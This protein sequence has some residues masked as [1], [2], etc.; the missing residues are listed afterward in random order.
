MVMSQVPSGYARLEKS[1]RHAVKNAS[2][3]GPAEPSEIV[4]VSI[5]VRRRPGAPPLPGMDQWASTRFAERK[6]ISREE[7][8]DKYG[9]D[10][11]DLKQLEDVA[12]T[13]ELKVIESSVPRRTVRLSGTVAQMSA[14]FG[15]SLGRYKS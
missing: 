10:P 5:R 11:A 8:A 6:Y 7:F 2:L 4:T 3:V 13:A 9:A 1:E 15:T 14:A 12:K